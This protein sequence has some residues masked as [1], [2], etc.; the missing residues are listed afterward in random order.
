M[1]NKT[2]TAISAGSSYSMLK[3]IESSLDPYTR[4]ALGLVVGSGIVFKR[5]D[6]NPVA[7][8][9]GIGIIIGSA[10]QLIDIA[11][12]GR[13][14]KNQCNLPVYII[15]E[16]GGVS[17]LEYGKV[18]S[19]NIDGFSFKGLNGVFKLSDGVYAKINT[20]NSIQYTPGLGRFIN[21]SLRSGG[22]KSKQWVDQQTDLRWK[23]LY[24]KTI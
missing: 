16:N 14:I 17:V 19:G 8:S 2:I 4:F 23:E 9:L 11:K 7:L 22:Y 18:P 20:N 21:Q 24:N 1:K 3:L 6:E 15:G 12:G 5:G 13:L 10:L